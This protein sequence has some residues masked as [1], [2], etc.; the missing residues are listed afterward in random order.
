V[1]RLRPFDNANLIRP[2]SGCKSFFRWPVTF[3]RICENRSK[4]LQV[5]VPGADRGLAARR[6]G[7]IA[8]AF[9]ARN[10]PA[11]GRVCRAGIGQERCPLGWW[12]LLY[13]ND[14]PGRRI[15][16][17]RCRIVAVTGPEKT[18]Y[19]TNQTRAAMLTYC[20]CGA[21]GCTFAPCGCDSKRYAIPCVAWHNK[22]LSRPSR[23][24][25]G[26]VACACVRLGVRR[27]GASCARDVR[28]LARATTPTG[29]NGASPGAGYR[30]RLLA[31]FRPR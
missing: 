1:C 11:R 31:I 17:E 21:V 26:R 22:R 19:G 24:R 8:G 18:E 14:W 6:V 9:R 3:L 15:G 7:A 27:A 2:G 23:A 25:D 28:A 30:L 13:R 29:G 12:W 16:Q 20:A 5:S 10:A 4:C